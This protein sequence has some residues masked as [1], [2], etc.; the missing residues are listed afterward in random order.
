MYSSHQ[1]GQASCKQTPFAVSSHK[2]R[3]VLKGAFI[4]SSVAFFKTPCNYIISWYGTSLLLHPKMKA[5]KKM[6]S[7]KMCFFMGTDLVKC[8]IASLAH[9]WILC[10]E[11]VPSEII[12]QFEMK[13]ILMMQ[14]VN[15]WTGG[16]WITCDVF[17]SCLDSHSDG[18]HSSVSKW[19]YISPNLM[20]KQ[21]HLHLGIMSTFSAN[22]KSTALKQRQMCPTTT[23]Y[24]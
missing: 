14:L 21:T 22:L 24:F 19:C 16:V 1:T 9:Q 18:T 23:Y 17:I 20:K 8:S 2:T 10:N 5:C 12:Q 11:W 13:N 4:Y 6:S 15:W 7:S 3:S